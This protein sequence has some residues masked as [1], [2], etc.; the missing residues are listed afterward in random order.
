V[1]VC[2]E[3]L[4]ETGMLVDFRKLKSAVREATS[5]LDHADLNALAAFKSSN[6][7]SENIAR[8]LFERL[9]ET[10]AGHGCRL[11]HVTVRETPDSSAT[12]RA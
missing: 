5:G 1:V 12:Y 6:P 8:H 11:D 7:T 3:E 10:L 4:D 9:R 2:G